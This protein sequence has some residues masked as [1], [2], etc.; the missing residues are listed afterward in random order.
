LY[1]TLIELR[2]AGIRPDQLTGD[3]AKLLEGYESELA[4]GSLVDLAGI[5]ALASEAAETSSH[6]F[7]GLPLV[8]LDAHLESLAHRELFA[9]LAARSP[10]VLAA[11]HFGEE[12]VEKILG[13]QAELPEEPPGSLQHLR[14]FLFSPNPRAFAGADGRFEFFSAPGEGLEAME[15]ARRIVK[16]AGQGVGFDQIAILLRNP[17]RYQPMIEEA[18]RRA[19]IPAWFTRG[20]ARPH[21]AGRAFLALLGCA[22]EKLSASRFAEYLSLGQ[23][24]AM[25]S[26]PV[27]IA[28]EDELLSPAAEE[29]RTPNEPPAEADRPMPRAWERLLVDAAVIGGRDRWE[30]R[31]DGLEAEFELQERDVE[32]LRNLKRFA[33]PLIQALDLLP[34]SAQWSV[35]MEQL[36]DLARLSLREPEPVLAVLAELAPMGEVGPV[37]LEEVAEVLGDRLRFLR[38]DPPARR[39]GRVFVGS[40]EDARAR[41]FA[42]VFLPG[43]A[44]GLF[45]QR[46]LEDP[47]LLDDLR[48]EISVDLPVR[49]G[50]VA[51]ER[52]LLHLAVAAARD[53]LV[54]SYPR[55]EVAEARP[56]VPSFYALEL[57]RAME[58]S[59]PELK[60]FERRAREAAPARLNWPAP[61]ESADAIDDAEYDLV[62]IASAKNQPGGAHYLL[63]ENPHVARSLRARWSRWKATWRNVDGLISADAAALAALQDHRLSAR[64]WSPSSLEQFAVCPYKFALQGIYRLRPREEAEALEQLDPRTRGGLFHAV[65]LDLFQRLKEAGLLPVNRDR[66]AEGLTLADAALDRVAAEYAEKLAP[67]IPRVWKSEIEDLRTDLRGWLQHAAA[68]DDEWVPAHFEMPFDSVDLAEGVRL[69]GRIDLVEKHST[70]DVFRVTDHKTGKRPDTIPRWVGGGKHLQPLLY[71]LVVEQELHGTVEAGRLL[72]A[73]QRGGYTPIEIKLDPRARQFVGRLLSNIDGA[74]ATG[75]LPPAPEKEACKFCDYRIVCGPYEER[76]LSKKDR[77]D[78]RLESLTEIRGMA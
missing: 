46:A 26:P 50:K 63:D 74:I 76:R 33:L 68:N 47:L 54:V 78:E 30:R 32:P 42:V 13:V 62:A 21:P 8:L 14:E 17:D 15:I 12:H 71:A 51:D 34:R 4:G 65:Q 77:R 23:A 1:R 44:E 35:W 69:R 57:P 7:L 58:G 39:W 5:L 20:V 27:W 64:A 66:L 37:T 2:L 70:R 16:L 45:P 6:P 72:Y 60:D 55:M 22:A 73:T 59:L 61:R 25:P 67:A 3:L 52:M 19:G 53:R 10:E 18:L 40:V 43:L 48:R 31:L 29:P 38:R 24:P 56:R 11:V 75:F 28:P 49:P 9:R 36:A 41:E